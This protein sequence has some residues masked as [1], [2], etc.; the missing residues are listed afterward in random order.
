[1]THNR[2][3]IATLL[4]LC[5]PL[6]GILGAENQT[7]PTS[8][9]N[10]DN[11][12]WLVTVPPVWNFTTILEATNDFNVTNFTTPYPAAGVPYLVY[13]NGTY[14]G[15]ASNALS[16]SLQQEFN[17][18]TVTYSDQTWT[19]PVV[20]EWP[21]SGMYSRLNRILYY[22]ALVFALVVRHHDWLVAGALASAT[23]YSGSAAIQAWVRSLMWQLIH[24]A[25]G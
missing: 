4:W 5:L 25:D 2:F 1:M 22:V 13:V 7:L 16:Y 18:S 9:F 15:Y 20:C 14:S 6:R 24:M 12:S 3:S 23:T 8:F 11:S 21:I 17:T 10:N 19:L